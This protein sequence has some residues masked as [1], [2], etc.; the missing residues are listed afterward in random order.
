MRTYKSQPSRQGCVQKKTYTTTCSGNDHKHACVLLRE[1]IEM[2]SLNVFYFLCQRGRFHVYAWRQIQSISYHVCDTEGRWPLLN[3]V[4]LSKSHENFLRSKH[5]QLGST[6]CKKQNKV[7][8][9][10]HVKS[11]RRP[12]FNSLTRKV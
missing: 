3:I 6:V 8:I 5:F 1:T 7:C 10:V 11:M 12:G 9:C 4:E 2:L